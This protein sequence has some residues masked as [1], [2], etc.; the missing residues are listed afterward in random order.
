LLQNVRE[1]FEMIASFELNFDYVWTYLEQKRCLL[2]AVALHYC[3]LIQ[4]GIPAGPVRFDSV[5][6]KP[7]VLGLF[8]TFAA[9]GEPAVA[10]ECANREPD[11]PV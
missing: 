5:I 3:E 1:V 7:G 9:I 10:R 2:D 4:C 11:G 6:S 8:R